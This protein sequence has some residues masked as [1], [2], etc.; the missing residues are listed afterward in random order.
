MQH[1]L[2]AEINADVV[3][4]AV[5]TVE[6]DQVAGFRVA[7]RQERVKLC[8]AVA[9]QAEALFGEDV[10]HQAGAI[11]AFRAVT[12]VAVRCADQF[13]AAGNQAV[14]GGIGGE[15]PFRR[16]GRRIAFQTFQ[17]NAVI[18]R[19]GLARH[20]AATSECER[21][22]AQKSFFLHRVR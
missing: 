9:R 16:S 2:V 8:A 18:E 12:A 17:F 5:A 19:H 21:Q 15:H 20:T 6:K 14:T 3:D 7:Y 4:V 13:L 11:K 22:Y 1:L 10:L